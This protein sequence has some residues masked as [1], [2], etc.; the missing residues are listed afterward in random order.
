MALKEITHLPA[1]LSAVQE[2]T[3][4]S[5]K[6]P[7][8]FIIGD[9]PGYDP[10]N[11]VYMLPGEPDST[12]ANEE[13]L[14]LM[15][16]GLHEGKAE[17]DISQWM[18]DDPRW[19]GD[20]SA[21]VLVNAL[22]D[23]RIDQVAGK[24]YPGYQD[25][26]DFHYNEAAAE[27]KSKARDTP[28]S[29]WNS[30]V[31]IKLGTYLNRTDVFPDSWP[32]EAIDYCTKQIE[33]ALTHD[34]N[35]EQPWVDHACDMMRFFKVGNPDQKPKPPPPPPE[36]GGEPQDED[37]KDGDKKGDSEG[38]GGNADD[39]DEDKEGDG[40]PQGSDSDTDAPEE[41][42]DAPE[43]PKGDQDPSGDKESPTGDSMPSEEGGTELDFGDTA[44]P[45]WADG[46]DEDKDFDEKKT[47]I[48]SI[49]ANVKNNDRIT[50]LIEHFTCIS[51]FAPVISH[52]SYGPSGTVADTV[53]DFDAKTETDLHK[54]WVKHNRDSLEQ[55]GNL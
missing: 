41:P 14:R 10:I 9:Q 27:F 38:G 18:P 52:I 7:P 35:D 15:F 3:I 48:D 49:T 24:M 53:H 8:K 13:F 28:P 36:E 20:Q 51:V 2:G 43:G 37:K 32:Q 40:D 33:R 1:L 31:A 16:F 34:I 42:S 23:A 26:A 30:A 5:R 19:A 29:I 11:N 6:Q 39:K 54:D 45:P 4:N 50:Y 21:M 46:H 47:V 44:R 12:L 22:V 55:T 17:T 25:S